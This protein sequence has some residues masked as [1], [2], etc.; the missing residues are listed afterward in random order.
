MINQDV[1]TYKCVQSRIV[2]LKQ[3]V[4]AT[5]VTII[6][7]SYNK[8]TIIIQIIVQKYKMRAPNFSVASHLAVKHQIIMSLKY[9][10]IGCVYVVTSR[11]T[12]RGFIINV[13]KITCVWIAF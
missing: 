4:S 13:C 2:I 6:R 3:Y 5:P 8:N 10:K 1:N 9:K 12:S 7:V 11:V